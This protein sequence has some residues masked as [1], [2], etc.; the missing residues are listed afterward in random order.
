[1]LKCVIVDDDAMCRLAL[2]R[3]VQLHGEVKICAIC[4][5]GQDLLD[6]LETEMV[7]LIFLDINMPDYRGEEVLNRIPIHIPVVITTG[8]DDM[9]MADLPASVRYLIY[10]PVGIS[11]FQNALNSLV[12]K[13]EY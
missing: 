5:N 8:E 11:E 12:Q 7:D 10:K 13:W 4:K 2:K 9:E 6:V 1:M 3:L